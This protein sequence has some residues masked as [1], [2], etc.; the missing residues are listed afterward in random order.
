MT[1]VPRAFRFRWQLAGG[2]DISGEECGR[3]LGAFTKGRRLFMKGPQ[4][5]VSNHT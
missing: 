5:G 1:S 4:R 3:R 2:E